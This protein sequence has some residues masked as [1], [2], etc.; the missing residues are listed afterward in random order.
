MLAFV[1]HYI[2]LMD[3]AIILITIK[4]STVKFLVLAF[5]QFVIVNIK[6]MYEAIILVTVK[7][8][9]VKFLK[10]FLVSRGI[11]LNYKSIA[12]LQSKY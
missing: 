3:E 4:I 7:V 9:P 2:K 10:S 6:L 12:L 11:K 8:P 5:C 1:N